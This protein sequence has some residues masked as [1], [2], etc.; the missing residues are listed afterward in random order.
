MFL[1]V[2]QSKGYRYLLLVENYWENGRHRQK[3]HHNFGRH[4]LID[5]AEVDRI[6][7]TKDQFAFLR[8]KVRRN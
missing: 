1:R 6:L 4:D 2:K 7:A 3:I 8:E 5:P